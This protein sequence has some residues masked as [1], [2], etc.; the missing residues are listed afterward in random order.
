MHRDSIKGYSLYY[1]VS[2]KIND[3]KLEYI[4][5]TRS[6]FNMKNFEQECIKNEGFNCFV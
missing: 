6:L 5:K 4:F 2:L 1:Q 3:I